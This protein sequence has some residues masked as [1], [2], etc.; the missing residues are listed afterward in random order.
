[1][2]I[3]ATK[4]C[5]QDEKNDKLEYLTKLKTPRILTSKVFHH[6]LGSFLFST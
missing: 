2:K 1:M 4:T 5:L 6:A 3:S